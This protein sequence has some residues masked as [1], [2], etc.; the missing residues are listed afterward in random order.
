MYSVEEKNNPDILKTVENRVKLTLIPG[1]LK[2]HQDP[3]LE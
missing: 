1:V 3:L 2:N